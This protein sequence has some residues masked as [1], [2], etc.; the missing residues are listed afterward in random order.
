MRHP[1]AALV[2]PVLGAM[3]DKWAPERLL[4]QRRAHGGWGIC[5]PQTTRRRTALRGKLIW[6]EATAVCREGRA[7]PRQL[8][9]HR[10]SSAEI[11][12]L[13]DQ[14]ACTVAAL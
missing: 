7:N 1:R 10:G 9:I 4:E 2:N 8:W 11:A 14:R 13:V 5:E 12:R 3:A 6:F